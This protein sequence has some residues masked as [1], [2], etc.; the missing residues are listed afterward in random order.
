MAIHS[1]F[2]RNDDI[3]QQAVTDFIQKYDE[4]VSSDD[5][6]NKWS[7]EERAEFK[8]EARKIYGDIQ[9]EISDF[10]DLNEKF[11]V[12]TERQNLRDS[13]NEVRKGMNFLEKAEWDYIKG[14]NEHNQ[15][16]FYDLM[17]LGNSLVGDT[18]SA[19][20]WQQ[21]HDDLSENA[22]AMA[23][24]A[25]SF[26][27]AAADIWNDNDG[28]AWS[29]FG[30]AS[31]SAVTDLGA[32]MTSA[33]TV[34][35]GAAGK[36]LGLASKGNAM[37][38]GASKMWGTAVA[39]K[40]GQLAIKA[41]GD[42]VKGQSLKSIP[43]YISM[44][45]PEVYRN[46]YV[47]K[48]TDEMGNFLNTNVAPT[49]SETLTSALV[50][51][52]H[53]WVE[54]WGIDPM[55]I[56]DAPT[57]KVASVFFKDFVKG[58]L[59]EGTEE[60]IQD[61]LSKFNE[62]LAR[63][64]LGEAFGATIGWMCSKEGLLD[65]INSFLG[66]AIGGAGMH[67]GSAVA[68]I[69]KGGDGKYHQ[70]VVKSK[71]D[72]AAEAK[73]HDLL[74]NNSANIDDETYMAEEMGL[75]NTDEM[76]EGQAKL[77][78]LQ[79]LA[80][81]QQKILEDSKSSIEDK[82]SAARMLGNLETQMEAIAQVLGFQ[83]QTASEIIRGNN[84]VSSLASEA[85]STGVAPSL[86]L[87]PDP[88][89]IEYTQRVADRRDEGQ[90]ADNAEQSNIESMTPEQTDY[91]DTLNRIYRETQTG[92]DTRDEFFDA[93]RR[94][95]AIVNEDGSITKV[96][97]D[98]LAES[99]SEILRNNIDGLN[100]DEKQT[101]RLITR[102][103]ESAVQSGP[104]AEEEFNA[105]LEKAKSAPN[106]SASMNKLIDSLSGYV[107]RSNAE[108]SQSESDQ[109]FSA[110]EGQSVNAEEAKAETPSQ[111]EKAREVPSA[112][113][114]AVG[115]RIFKSKRA[116]KAYIKQKKLRNHGIRD[117]GGGQ[118]EVY[119]KSSQ[120]VKKAAQNA[121]KGF[122]DSE[123][124]G[125]VI[126][127]TRIYDSFDEANEAMQKL[128]KD[129]GNLAR[130]MVKV[131]KADG[132]Y[133]Y[134]IKEQ[135]G[136]FLTEKLKGRNRVSSDE[137]KR[138]VDN[139]RS[140][141]KNKDLNIEIHEDERDYLGDQAE[142]GYAE[143]F[144]DNGTI[145]LFRSNIK[146]ADRAKRVLLHELTHYGF[147][148]LLD[149]GEKKNVLNLFN[150]FAKNI[151][152]DGNGNVLFDVGGYIVALNQKYMDSKS[153]N[154]SEEVIEEI[155]ANMAEKYLSNPK[156]F[157]EKAK[158]FLQQ[159]VA[160]VRRG[161]R[162]LG[163]D[164][165]LSNSEVITFLRD[166]RS[167]IADQGIL[168]EN[169]EPM[170]SMTRY[171]DDN[172]RRIPSTHPLYSLLRESEIKDNS[173]RYFEAYYNGN[174]KKKSTLTPIREN[175]SMTREALDACNEQIAQ[176]QKLMQPFY[177][178]TINGNRYLPE[179]VY[180]ASTL[181]D[182][183]SY[184][185]TMENTT[186]CW[187]TL[188]YI[189]FCDEVKKK[190]GRPLTVR[191]SF[192]VSQKIYDMG[193]DPQCLYCYV[194]LDRKSYDEALLK[195]TQQRDSALSDYT[196]NVKDKSAR[197]PAQSRAKK[198][199]S[200]NTARVAETE[201]GK[202][203]MRYL[204]GREDSPVQRDR[205]NSWLDIVNGDNKF[206]GNADLATKDIR[207]T[208]TKDKVPQSWKNC[209]VHIDSIMADE[210]LS[211]GQKK[212]KISD[213]KRS[214]QYKKAWDE[215]RNTAVGQILD[216]EAYAQAS[217]WQ[218]KEEDYRSYMGELLT[219]S[220]SALD[221][222]MSHY[223]LRFYSF[224]EYTGAFIL[225]NMQMVRDAALRG[226]KG[227]AYTKKAD[228]ARIFAPTGMNFNIG[229][230]GRRDSKGN[231]VMDER[232]GANWDE[233][234]KLRKQYDGVG[235]VFVAVDDDM[236]R[237]ALDQD[238]ID[239]IIPFHIVRTGDDIAKYYGWTNFK[240]DQEDQLVK[241]NGKTKVDNIYPHQHHN[242]KSD[243]IELA[244]S[245]GWISKG[246]KDN[247][248]TPRFEQFIDHPN[249]MRL[250]NETRRT[251]DDTP[252]LNPTFDMKAAK[253]AFKEFTDVGGY[254]NNFY[255][256]EY[257]FDEET[258]LVAEDI[259]QGK[260]PM[261]VD[262]GRQDLP[263]DFFDKQ[264]KKA[265][266]RSKSRTHGIRFSYVKNIELP[267]N[268]R[269]SSATTFSGGG[270]I[271]AGLE[272][273]IAPKAAL[274]Y[275]SR[276]ASVYRDNH[277]SHM[278]VGS[279]L[280]HAD[281]K[282]MYDQ[283]GKNLGY[284]HASP[285]CHNFSMAKNDKVETTEDIA[286]ARSTAEAIT[287]MKP[288]VF[289]CEN[290]P[291]Y[292]NSKSFKVIADALDKN[293]YTWDAKVYHHDRFGGATK[294][295]R[296]IVRA[297]RNGYLPLVQERYN[298]KDKSWYE[299]VKDL[300]QS[301]P[302]KATD[303]TARQKELFG[304]TFIKGQPVLEYIKD[305][306]KAVW[307]SGNGHGKWRVSSMEEPAPTITARG[308]SE[309]F[310]LLPNGE[311]KEVTPRMVARLM[312][313][314]DSYKVPSSKTLAHL[315]LGNGVPTEITRA[316]ILPL[317][318]DN[319]SQGPTDDSNGPKSK[320]RFSYVNDTE[321][322]SEANAD[323]ARAYAEAVKDLGDTEEL[324]TILDNAKKNNTLGKAPNG[325]QSNLEP[326]Q[327]LMVRTKQFK[328]WFGDWEKK[329][330]ITTSKDNSDLKSAEEALLNI[331]KKD[332]TNDETGIVAKIS[333]IQRNKLLSQKAVRKSLENGF[334]VGK[335]NQA[336]A[337]IDKL[338][339]S[340]SLI[341]SEADKNNDINI[342]SIK[343]FASP[344][345]LEKEPAIGYITVKESL[346]AGHRVYSLELFEIKKFGGKLQELINDKHLV[347]PNSIS[348]INKKIDN[349]NN[350]SK[351]VDENG[352]PLVVWHGTESA[353]NKFDRT[354]T[355]A[356]MD[357]Q[358]NF[359]SPWEDDAKGY[360]RNVRKFFIKLNNPA[361]FGQGLKALKIFQGLNKA[362]E[363]AANYLI[364]NGYDGVNNDNEEYI[365]FDSENIKSADS[366]TYDDNNKPIP[367]SE[368][369]NK[370][371]KDIRYSYVKEENEETPQKKTKASW[372]EWARQIKHMRD[373]QEE[374]RRK[375]EEFNNMTLAQKIKSFLK[376]LP[377][378]YEQNVSNHKHMLKKFEEE[379]SPLFESGTIPDNADPHMLL[380]TVDGRIQNKR[381]EF[382]AQ[383][384]QPII[385]FLKENKI[386]S[387]DFDLYL[388]AK[389]AD[390][391]DAQINKINPDLA[392]RGIRGSGWN[393]QSM[394][395][396]SAVQE[397]LEKKYPKISEAADMFY[398]MND[399]LLD[400]Q[401]DYGLVSKDHVENIRKIYPHYCPLKR[402][403]DKSL[404]DGI[405][406]GDDRDVPNSV[407]FKSDIQEALGRTSRPEY[408]FM[409]A[410]VSLDHVFRNGE[411][412]LCN[413]A[414]YLF[415]EKINDPSM[416]L[417]QR[418]V[419]RKLDPNRG[420]IV[421]RYSAELEPQTVVARFKGNPATVHIDDPD[422]Y[423]AFTSPKSFIGL[424]NQMARA[425]RTL[426]APLMQNATSRNVE[427]GLVNAFKDNQ[428]A[429]IDNANTHGIKAATNI[430]KG[431]WEGC[432][433]FIDYE[434]GKDTENT[435]LFK[436]YLMNGG[437][438]GYLDMLRLDKY[439]DNLEKEINSFMITSP[440]QKL[441]MA[442]KHP[443][444][445]ADRVLQKTS[446]YFFKYFEL[447]NEMM[448]TATRFANYKWFRQ[449]GGKDGG[450]A[451][452]L[453]AAEFAKNITLNFNRHGAKWTSEW[454]WAFM[455]SNA[456]LQGGVK[457]LKIYRKMLTTK[458]GIKALVGIILAG[459][460][461]RLLN[462]FRSGV[463]EEDGI[464]YYD[465]IPDYKKKSHVII[466]KSNGKEYAQ[467]PLAPVI[468]LP[469]MF[470][471]NIGAWLTNK[472]SLPQMIGDSMLGILDAVNPLGN[473]SRPLAV[474]LPTATRPLFDITTNSTWSGSKIHPEPAPFSKVKYPKWQSHM[475][476]TAQIY[477]TLCKALNTLSG[478]N[479]D[480]PGAIDLY[481]DDVSHLLYSYLGGMPRLAAKYASAFD[482]KSRG[483]NLTWRETP[484]LSRWA[485]ESDDRKDYDLW[486]Q[487]VDQEAKELDH[488]P[489]SKSQLV[490]EI[491]N[492]NKA[493]SRIKSD[494][495]K[496][497]ITD[498]ER[499]DRSLAVKKHA[500]K[501]LAPE[502]LK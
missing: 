188:A 362:G 124:N 224:S 413:Q 137:L 146:D 1:D 7:P 175:P 296:L 354:K 173:D 249:Y 484:I 479:N 205:F 319:N 79:K 164:I 156:T 231:V 422:V 77:I 187:R 344:V 35:T 497:K 290:A 142:T 63:K 216:A 495:N 198:E 125:T 443:F 308:A 388:F 213:F 374:K 61:T 341:I 384:A 258:S 82:Q 460:F 12:E 358:G 191:E 73:V 200:A 113:S 252:V 431:F 186:V 449:H 317:L 365:V 267:P 312:G 9:S 494:F 196:D 416:Q 360:G 345:I 101:A 189:K 313:L 169:D 455:F 368:R 500:I 274:E 248:F 293:G 316:V 487:L 282:K 324:K 215:V 361:T 409:F 334:T 452:A 116:A 349:V 419:I 502:Y 220:K 397:R 463:D 320:R 48:N 177:E 51:I 203:Y 421:Y 43:T 301:A 136:S 60:V 470:G 264:E 303:F 107:Q 104:Q 88:N 309:E 16:T 238:W 31:L 488:N 219:T 150:K 265:N 430:L 199:R 28:K 299:S 406:Y 208:L 45:L 140:R 328:D 33:P 268:K 448:E 412:N 347:A 277:G 8:K 91:F 376:E 337:I 53:S 176:M 423:I 19:S 94:G 332:L 391:R 493:L 498:K 336:V 325:E 119:D 456:A 404:L 239:V 170:G 96:D 392:A 204:N 417:G 386:T 25:K 287:K 457:A 212:K 424:S 58:C 40:S 145:H 228:F 297:V 181:F 276:I 394:G 261:E 438:T 256:P 454:N 209:C 426:T 259:R 288:N 117:L 468:A 222:V 52:P 408:P 401:L 395:T 120:N 400:I 469:Y 471:D 447:F 343:R 214:A 481:P 244:K 206:V 201:L 161:L 151:G 342:K 346:E 102:K 429:F 379:K 56:A 163:F 284:F 160:A 207:H 90:S 353:F 490:R 47:A 237:W 348:N 98:S 442:A 235:A 285:V 453:R 27:Q 20:E 372:E 473:D 291:L 410:L 411:M 223:G 226:L 247:K 54:S 446:G 335:H 489:N 266:D 253:K 450:E 476:D 432:R 95:E 403:D 57:K 78:E 74:A 414:L 138:I 257:N 6:K 141:L 75:I 305:K 326:A 260:E 359:F 369:Y 242:S 39:N 122:A 194:S 2:S 351:V 157:T 434:R 183:A 126:R 339:K 367:Q 93:V 300:I 246:N 30:E 461:G 178:K 382:Y 167:N 281:V 111:S 41:A 245:K 472:I 271:E 36:A 480:T 17:A 466:M 80:D 62:N 162:S 435:R 155:I 310:I 37:M 387:T 193:T 11:E 135:K 236:V 485:G 179:E 420:E 132:T 377:D 232:Q 286:F 496:G 405:I 333:R 131:K 436:E 34:L 24:E 65:N 373:L 396:P 355:R 371:N 180:G 492:A 378:K 69:Y 87:N 133:G 168:F 144:Y 501:V 10:N 323:E 304:N 340:A 383:N 221:K 311:I 121:E 97:R 67:G 474:F 110:D 49:F 491:Q 154:A 70:G 127:G 68:S 306:N 292:L 182:N 229:C 477:V 158:R 3:N 251:A 465:K 202:V 240:A 106:K 363:K 92:Y 84:N 478:G 389:H 210:S 499:N 273:I 250:V 128:N 294:R 192:L 230:Y 437:S 280:D 211:D 254:Y 329:Y 425:F 459:I 415:A 269:V 13:G 81:E 331:S 433:T 486:A 195:Y 352:E 315:I 439:A 134:V 190:I 184:G 42:W 148:Q 85:L 278:I 76:R 26:T 399:K 21:K 166:I 197:L 444:K 55:K 356:N 64:P 393:E 153:E 364:K 270:L 475:K 227:F 129:T 321:R 105:E 275:D 381:D 357:I 149:S 428:Q 174:G 330:E 143:G 464:K 322:S 327:W 130:R 46:L 279:V 318:T 390:E 159:I 440:Y 407:S 402:I 5:F 103:A 314:P 418:K 295:T 441:L 112:S 108:A 123:A 482:K 152:R 66:G 44:S 71:A 366:V 243:F 234:K 14:L 15:G 307:I 241:D 427:F 217:S 89:S 165:G 115:G 445:T 283:A 114:D 139:V 338:F 22:R 370:E 467:L 462:N 4:I 83:V 29:E 398:K 272:G 86:N 99:A 185:K 218:K 147:S 32:L 255:R 458:D 118:Y 50:A 38:R 483:E 385:D 72:L 263:I 350:S 451:S 100:E 59:G 23:G 298:I 18:K 172:G 171:T 302:R 375:K 262:Y 225:E 380:D 109:D 289:T 233:V